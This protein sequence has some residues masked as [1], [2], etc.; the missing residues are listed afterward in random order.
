[1][2]L[3]YQTSVLVKDVLH[4]HVHVSACRATQPEV[5]S[6]LRMLDTSTITKSVGEGMHQRFKIPKGGGG[7][8]G[9]GGG[10]LK[11]WCLY[12]GACVCM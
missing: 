3:G 2:C 8:G 12:E 6:A 7:G 4:V 5:A 9:G 10:I 11:S 1:M